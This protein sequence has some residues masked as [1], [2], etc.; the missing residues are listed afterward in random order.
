MAGQMNGLESAWA[1]QLDIL[2]AAGEVVWWG[3]ETVK[4]RLAKNTHITIDF[5]V[6]LADGTIEFQDTKGFWRDDARAKTKVAAELFPMFRFVA[7]TKDKA[8]WKREV[9]GE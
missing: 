4:L 8:G 7:M 1:V 6:M 5:M 2:K 9:I 3:F